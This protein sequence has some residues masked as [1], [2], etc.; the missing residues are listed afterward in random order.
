MAKVLYLSLM[1]LRVVLLQRV[2]HCGIFPIV[3]QQERPDDYTKRVG[4]IQ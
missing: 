2:P 1:L 3:Q 4:Y